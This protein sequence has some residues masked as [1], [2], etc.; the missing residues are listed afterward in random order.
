VFVSP[1]IPKIEQSIF[2]QWIILFFWNILNW[3]R[4]FL[5]KTYGFLKTRVDKSLNIYIRKL[6]LFF[7]NWW[8]LDISERF[9]SCWHFIRM[10]S[11]RWFDKKSLLYYER[12]KNWTFYI[13]LCSLTLLVQMIM[14]SLILNK[15]NRRPRSKARVINYF[16]FCFYYK[17]GRLLSMKISILSQR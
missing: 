9:I 16:W 3:S 6:Y 4:M 17:I 12:K 10:L 8:R 13:T 15:K 7:I 1:Y 5:N 2:L 11:N 14:F